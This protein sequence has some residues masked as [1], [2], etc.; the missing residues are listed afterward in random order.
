MKHLYPLWACLLCL[1]L[2]P[3][4][5]FGTPRG[6]GGLAFALSLELL[7]P[8]SCYGQT[9]AVLQG[10]FSGGVAPYTVVYLIDGTEVDGGVTSDDVNTLTNLPPGGYTVRATDATGATVTES[11]DIKE[12]SVIG[13]DLIERQDIVCFGGT[14]SITVS[15]MG[16]TPPYS[17]AWSTGATSATVDNLT[18]GKYGVTVTDANGCTDS[19]NYWIKGPNTE[20]YVSNTNTT[21]AGCGDASDGQASVAVRGGVSPYTYRWSNGATGATATGLRA[22]AYTVTVTDANGCEVPA[23]VTVDGKPAPSVTAEQSQMVSCAGGNDGAALASATGGTAPYTYLW[24]NGA[25]T[26]QVTNVKGGTYQVTVT[27][28]GG[29]T[30]VAQVRINQ[31]PALSLA[32]FID[33]NLGCDGQANGAVSVMANGG[34]EPYTYKWSTGATESFLMGVGAGTYSATVTDAKGCTDVT[35][36]ELTE[37]AGFTIDAAVDANVTCNQGSDGAVSVSATGTGDYTYAWSNGATTAS[38][39][40]LKAG[41]YRVTVTG[42]GG[43]TMSESVTVTQPTALSAVAFTDANASCSGKTDGMVSVFPSGGASSDYTYAWSNGST[44]QFLMAVGAGE[45]TVT[46]TDGNGCTATA[47]ATVTEPAG[48]VAS[49]TVDANVS[50]NGGADG[51]VTASLTGGSGN[52]TYAWSNAATTA[53]VTGLRAGDYSVTISDNKGCSATTSVTVTEPTALNAEMGITQDYGADNGTAGIT[54]AGGTG[55]YT[56]AWGTDPAQTES[57]ATGLTAGAYTVTVTDANGCTLEQTAFISLAGDTCATAMAID[58]LFGS[59]TDETRYSR[60][61]VNASY[62][63]DSIANTA[64]TAY[65]AGNDT[66]YHPVWFNFT[67][68]GNIYHIRTNRCDA[69]GALR[70]TRAALFMNACGADTLLRASDNYSETDSM[71]LIEIATEDGVAYTLLVDGADSTAGT[72]CLAVTQMVTVPVRTVRPAVLAAFPNPTDGIIRFP[73]IEGREATVFDGFGRSVLRRKLAAS[74]LDLGHLPAGVYTLRVTDAQQAVY[75]ARVVK[76]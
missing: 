76:Q 57:L 35:S 20:L 18:K 28:A 41:T 67:G 74:E 47:R 65:F 56:Y 51:S 42:T 6:D 11:I 12:P 23:S 31:S 19:R 29:C 66:L 49:T 15:G 46:V 53:T 21:P 25:T 1:F 5:S 73:G 26:A 32:G 40:G 61:F 43:C 4:T 54:V 22:G 75:T 52:L 16:G 68:D 44:E 60:A 34:V 10:T 2:L 36:I 63:R 48:Y 3:Q 9:D 45:Y 72:F 50:C 39:T 64:L 33:N 14:G 69:D 7:Q 37:P 13:F 27:D 17:Y 59:A 62:A 58:T 55:D 24:S 8:I 30:A 38:L 70:D 71:P